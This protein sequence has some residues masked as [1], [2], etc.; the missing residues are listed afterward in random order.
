MPQNQK[1]ILFLL[2]QNTSPLSLYVTVC[3]CLIRTVLLVNPDECVPPEVRSISEKMSGARRSG[4]DVA[5]TLVLHSFQASLGATCDLRAL[6]AA[7]QTKRDDELDQLAEA[8]TDHMEAAASAADPETARRAL[9]H[10][11][12]KLRDRVA[13]PAA[14][15]T[16]AGM[17]DDVRGG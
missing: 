13:G 8:V 14:V 5:I 11:M 10:V 12:E 17:T 9:L 7:L 2:L 4:R 16:D 15:C 1:Y 3:V 6:H